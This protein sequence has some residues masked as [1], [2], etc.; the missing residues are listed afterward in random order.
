MVMS[1]ISSECL[2]STRDQVDAVQLYNNSVVL[3]HLR[4]LVCQSDSRITPQVMDEYS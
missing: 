4:L 2:S 3:V 1:F